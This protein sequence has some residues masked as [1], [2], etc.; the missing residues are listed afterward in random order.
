MKKALDALPLEEKSSELN[1]LATLENDIEALILKSCE[2]PRIEA[3]LQFNSE[4]LF[5][6][7]LKA[8]PLEYAREVI[9]APK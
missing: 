4:S 3:L 7:I 6:N 8:L 1:E 9:K 5:H 2:S